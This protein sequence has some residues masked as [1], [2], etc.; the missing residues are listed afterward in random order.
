MNL[1]L[2]AVAVASCP[3]VDAAEDVHYRV[4]P[5]VNDHENWRRALRRLGAGA[6]G[7]PATPVTNSAITE[8]RIIYPDAWRRGDSR[9]LA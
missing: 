2:T 1:T 5:Q 8:V 4:S 9:C 3:I 7:L 6:S